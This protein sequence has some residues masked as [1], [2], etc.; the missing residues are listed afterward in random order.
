[1]CMEMVSAK[2]IYYNNKNTEALLD[3]HPLETPV[4][5]QLFGSEP[6]LI[7]EMAKRIEERPFSILDFNMGCPVP[8]I[9]NNK[10]GS[11]LMKDP[12]LAEEILSGLVKAVQKPVTVKIRKGF[13]EEH[14][15]GV[16]LA[17][18]AESCGVAAIAVHG[19]TRE[20]Y[21]SGRADWDMIRRVKEAVKIPVIGNGD[22]D[23]PLAAV[24]MM[25]ET[26]CDGVMIGRAAQGNPWIFRDTVR[27]LE[28]GVIPEPPDAIEKKQ[29]ILEHVRLQ[30]A[31]KGEYTAVREMRKH[32]A[33]YTF[34]MP[35]SAR[36]RQMINSMET[37]DAL[38]EGVETIFA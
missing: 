6:K 20:Q 33:W 9:V 21:Y 17:K 5:L 35:H 14:C 8:K 19:R 23:G 4:S 12:R 22:V 26:G 18:I 28:D 31:Q 30:M 25:E 1:M 7:A 38:L 2:A 27:F 10:E 34:G 24:K 13:D 11:A 37:M 15:N 36:F 3:I 29:L 16:E 32:L